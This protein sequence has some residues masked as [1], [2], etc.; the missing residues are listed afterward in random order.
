MVSL[1]FVTPGFVSKMIP[2]VLK[3]FSS[4]AVI[5]LKKFLIKIHALRNCFLISEKNN[6]SVEGIIHN[7]VTWRESL[8]V[9][10]ASKSGFS[11]GLDTHV[12]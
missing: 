6:Y 3:L 10:S 1:E 2:D 12:K 4:S 7:N 8:I 9:R 5:S 11:K